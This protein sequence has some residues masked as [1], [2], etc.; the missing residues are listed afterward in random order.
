MLLELAVTHC[1]ASE[2]GATAPASQGGVTTGA[3]LP[4]AASRLLCM[5]QICNNANTLVHV[6]NLDYTHLPHQ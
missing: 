1:L 4:A 5:S 2:A 3:A 6:A